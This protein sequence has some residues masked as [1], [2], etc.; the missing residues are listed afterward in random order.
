MRKHILVYFDV[1]VVNCIPIMLFQLVTTQ[2]LIKIERP[3]SVLCC[4]LI[5]YFLIIQTYS[6]IK[7][8]TCILGEALLLV[9]ELYFRFKAKIVTGCLNHV[10]AMP[11]G[12]YFLQNTF[13]TSESACCSLQ[14]CWL[15]NALHQFSWRAKKLILAWLMQIMCAVISKVCD[16]AR[17]GCLGGSTCMFKYLISKFFIIKKF[18]IQ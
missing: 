4:I 18:G 17:C 7:T 1:P 3:T 14:W 8:P 2:A 11:M 13:L 6:V 12:P 5:Q 9:G 10:A 16:M 15:C